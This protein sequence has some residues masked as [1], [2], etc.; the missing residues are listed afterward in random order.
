MGI[1]VVALIAILLL[2]GCTSMRP[3]GPV[4]TGQSNQTA[5]RNRP[6]NLSE[7]NC[8]SNIPFADLDVTVH[9]LPGAF[10]KRKSGR[11]VDR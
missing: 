5:G 6:Y 10:S 9:E 3:V 11:Y 2:C 8:D 7:S 1:R 4:P